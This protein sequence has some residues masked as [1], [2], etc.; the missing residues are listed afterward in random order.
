MTLEDKYFQNLFQKSYIIFSIITAL[1]ITGGA[2]SL[3]Y[4]ILNQIKDI[5]KRQ[6]ISSITIENMINY[7][8]M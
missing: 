4:F 7:I 5:F 1:G 6:L 3:F 8:H 2:I